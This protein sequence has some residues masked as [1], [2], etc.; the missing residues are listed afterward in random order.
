MKCEYGV[1]PMYYIDGVPG[2]KA[3]EW[4]GLKSC[5]F[6]ATRRNIRPNSNGIIFNENEPPLVTKK[7]LLGPN[8]SPEYE[9]KPSYKM[10]K[11]ETDKK[12]K[13][14]SIK[15][16]DFHPVIAKDR[17]EKRH[18]FQ[19]KVEFKK[20]M[21]EKE[22][23]MNETTILSKEFHLLQTI[24]F[25]KKYYNE[26]ANNKLLGLAFTKDKFNKI[27]MTYN[28]PFNFPE[29]A[30]NNRRD[31]VRQEKETM[32]NEISYVN[33]LTKWEEKAL[34]KLNKA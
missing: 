3:G 33:N 16:V 22:K 9:F 30:G 2:N 13:V 6:G 14:Q 1:G 20:A 25:K 17:P 19:Y 26:M 15:V 7:K 8:P 27:T 32:K 4:P 10:V 5:K 31:Q 23:Q 18:H 34:P 29:S 24:G 21:E 28:N 11:Q 12:D